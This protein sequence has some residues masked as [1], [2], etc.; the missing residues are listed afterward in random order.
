MRLPERYGKFVLVKELD[1]GSLGYDFRAI[2]LSA[3]GK[4]Q[5]VSL[6][7]INETLTRDEAGLKRLVTEAKASAQL[8]SPNILKIL[9]IGKVGD[10]YFISYPLLEAQTLKSIFRRSRREGFP[11]SPDHALLIASKMAR[12]LEYCHSRKF[13][14]SRYFHGSLYPS[15]VS[16]TYDG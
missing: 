13:E 10:S 5:P 9:A 6:L 14:G 15:S 16:I 4:P 3:D 7:R 1:F 11:L 2:E 8:A 12:A